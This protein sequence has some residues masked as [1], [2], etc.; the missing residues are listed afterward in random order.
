MRNMCPNVASCSRAAAASFWFVQRGLRSTASHSS[1]LL[2]ARRGCCCFCCCVSPQN[3][4][5]K[6][7][8]PICWYKLSSVHHWAVLIGFGRISLTRYLCH[9]YLDVSKGKRCD[10]LLWNKVSC[11]RRIFRQQQIK[12]L[13]GTL[14][15][16]IKV[17]SSRILSFFK[18]WL[19]KQ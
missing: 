15:G 5:G 4:L 19:I 2:S 3:I 10:H 8:K 13:S 17:N 9:Q 1:T 7:W 11:E 18:T 6:R 16:I 12:K 14:Q